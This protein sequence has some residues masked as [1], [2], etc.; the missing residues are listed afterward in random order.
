VWG[1]LDK[2]LYLRDGIRKYNDNKEY[3]KSNDICKDY[4]EL[5]K[6]EELCTEDKWFCYFMLSKNSMYL[7]DNKAKVFIHKA[8]QF[9]TNTCDYQE[10]I[11]LKIRVYDELGANKQMI[12]ALYDDNIQYLIELFSIYEIDDFSVDKYE[13]MN[14]LSAMYNNK[15]YLINGIEEYLNAI[16]LREDIIKNSGWNAEK[17]IDIQKRLDGIYEELCGLYLRGDNVPYIKIYSIINKI[18]NKELK[19]QLLDKMLTVQNCEHK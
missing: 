10:T 12:T 18:N 7:R 9:T 3:Q 2:Y 15:G 19:N 4:L 14:W 11:W 6:E 5:L 16:E 13:I 1:L 17:I 8:L